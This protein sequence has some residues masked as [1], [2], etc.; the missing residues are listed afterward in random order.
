[1]KK[2]LLVWVLVLSIAIVGCSKKTWWT[3]WS[4]LIS[5]AECITKAWATFY[6]TEWCPHCK[7]QKAMFGV[8]MKY[9]NFV[10][11]DKQSALCQSAWVTW[12][13]TWRFANGSTLQWTQ[14]LEA[15]ASKTN[16]PLTTINTWS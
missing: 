16:C 3:W 8:S 6:G 15:I 4:E 12:Y 10:D 2:L 5:F 14:P 1:M 11:C 13:P 7:D 9:V